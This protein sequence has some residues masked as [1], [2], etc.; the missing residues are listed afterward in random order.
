MG[1]VRKSSRKLSPE[2]TRPFTPP[3]SFMNHVLTPER[4]FATATLALADVK[5]TSKHLGVTIND[6]VLAISA[7][8]LRELLLKYDGQ[9]DH[10]LL[11]SVPVSFRLLAGPHLRQLLHWRAD[12]VADRCRGHR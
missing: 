6:L 5:E 12:G 8:A 4:H 3:P 11:A 1:R 9:A 7:G 2:L 10:P